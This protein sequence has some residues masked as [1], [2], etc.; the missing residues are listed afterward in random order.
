MRTIKYP[1]YGEDTDSL[2]EKIRHDYLKLYGPLQLSDLV[3]GYKQPCVLDYWLA[4]LSMGGVFASKTDRLVEMVAAV[5]DSNSVAGQLYDSI[6]SVGL[7]EELDPQ[8]WAAFVLG[9]KRGIDGKADDDLTRSFIN[10]VATSKAKADPS[11]TLRN[12][13]AEYAKGIAKHKYG[14]EQVG[15]MCS[16]F[17]LMPPAMPAPKNNPTFILIPGWS[18]LAGRSQTQTFSAVLKRLQGAFGGEQKV[19]LLESF[20]LDAQ[21]NGLSNFLG[22]SFSLLQTGE[23]GVDECLSDMEEFVTYSTEERR[24]VK[25]NLLELSNMA[26]SIGA[27]KIAGGWGDYRSDIGAKLSS[28]TSNRDRQIVE[29]ISRLESYVPDITNLVGMLSDTLPE[30]FDGGEYSDLRVGVGTVQSMVGGAVAKYTDVTADDLEAIGLVLSDLRPALNRWWQARQEEGLAD[31]SIREKDRKGVD[32]K[33]GA[34]AKDLPKL[35]VLLGESSRLR[36]NRVVNFASEYQAQ[37]LLLKE[38]VLQFKADK[39]DS[40]SA[41]DADRLRGW[42]RT[43]RSEW[44]RRVAADLASIL[45]VS[46]LDLAD[47]EYFAENPRARGRRRLAAYKPIDYAELTINLRLGELVDSIS[48]PLTAVSSTDEANDRLELIKIFV[49]LES[50]RCESEIRVRAVTPMQ[51]YFVNETG[52]LLSAAQGNT[53]LQTLVLADLRGLIMLASKQRFVER[54]AL[55]MASGNQFR[56]G[57]AHDDDS[58]ITSDRFY[59]VHRGGGASASEEIMVYEKPGSDSLPGEPKK[60]RSSSGSGVYKLGSSRYQKQ[61][62][63]WLR[64]KPKRRQN[65]LTF[66]GGFSIA[67]FDRRLVWNEECKPKVETVG[68]SRVFVSIPFSILAEKKEAAFDDKIGRIMGVDVGEKGLAWVIAEKREQGPEGKTRVRVVASGF[69]RNR[70]HEKLAGEVR[71]LRERQTVGTFSGVNTRVARLRESLVGSYRSQLDSIALAYHARL[72][73]ERQISAFESGGNR[74]QKVYASVKKSEVYGQVDADKAVLAHYY[75]KESYRKGRRAG[76]E[77]NAGGT[78][79][80]CSKCRRWFAKELDGALS[81]D[82]EFLSSDG[83]LGRVKTAGGFIMVYAKNGQKLPDSVSAKDLGGYV[84]A[85]MRPPVE[86]VAMKYALAN[87]PDFLDFGDPARWKEQNANSAIFICPYESC[88]HASDADIQAALN[89]ALRGFVKFDAPDKK[90]D[91]EETSARDVDWQG[92]AYTQVR[93]GFEYE[94]IGLD[95]LKRIY[96]VGKIDNEKSWKQLAGEHYDEKY[97]AGSE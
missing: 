36:L 95:P 14:A 43:V 9:A 11:G 55:Q 25:A 40:F 62:L 89:I 90:K 21:Y 24:A 93:D 44:G 75:G 32:Q 5:S 80:T 72:S 20:G 81:Y 86:S 48:S 61:F 92:I 30:G 85:F 57:F 16:L 22:K 79:Q 77:I 69:L 58:P 73:F 26:K 6:K 46:K 84:Y 18:R 2:A 39:V 63:W 59:V 47:D 37:F 29:I 82:V 67:E 64:Q 3:S 71:K 35:P 74:I 13:A 51:T 70:Q 4:A 96:A 15:F 68:V 33:F 54:A 38:I 87:S 49:G 7:K 23:S 60:Y 8:R 78:S 19:L 1:I 50:S 88:L 12:I 17:G 53:F 76:V 41:K 52:E 94:S 91:E 66:A 34:L 45:N 28:F 65:E 10:A 27:P 97:G 83:Y 56:L 31:G 42:A